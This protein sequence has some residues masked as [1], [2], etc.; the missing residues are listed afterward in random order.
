M[1]FFLG[2]KGVDVGVERGGRSGGGGGGGYV[3]FWIG[4]N[5]KLVV[6]WCGDS[7][8]MTIGTGR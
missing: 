4:F 2:F 5:V 7:V 6:F 1:F 8:G 3:M